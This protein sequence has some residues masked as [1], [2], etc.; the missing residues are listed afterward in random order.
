MHMWYRVICIGDV[1]AIAYR[2]IIGSFIS[3]T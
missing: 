2:G 3:V 1:G